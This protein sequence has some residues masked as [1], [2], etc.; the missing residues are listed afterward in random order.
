MIEYL[1]GIAPDSLQRCIWAQQEKP[2]VGGFERDSSKLLLIAAL[3]YIGIN[4][5][6][7]SH[8]EEI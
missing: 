3:Y 6:T 5:L 1:P 2:K 8:F 4:S 7:K